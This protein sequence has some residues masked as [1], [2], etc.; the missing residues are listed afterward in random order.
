MGQVETGVEMCFFW[1]GGGE[2]TD[3]LCFISSPST[4]SALNVY[5]L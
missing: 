2:V 3:R 5:T 1:E 4:F